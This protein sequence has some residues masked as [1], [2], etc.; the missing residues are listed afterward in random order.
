MY[1]TTVNRV[2]TTVI[3]NV[4]N[5]RITNVTVTRVSYNG[6]GG[7]QYR[8][9]PAEVMAIREQHTPPM[10]A[11]VQ[12]RQQAQTNRAMFYNSNHGRPA[13]VTESRP[14]AADRNVRPPAQI[15][16]ARGERPPV[17]KAIQQ[18]Q[19]A[20]APATR[21]EVRPNEQHARPEAHTAP[22]RTQP[23][24]PESRPAPQQQHAQPQ[25]PETQRATPQ[26]PEAQHA[27]PRRSAPQQEHG[28]TAPEKKPAPQHAAPR[29]QTHTTAQHKPEP[30]KKKP[31][32][33]KPE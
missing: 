20:A 28:R 9:R 6:P 18:Q 16:Y 12:I 11:Q 13:T 23:G 10:T 5:Y 8:P 4:Y 22:E 19:R 7:A 24:R 2:N 25:R 21:P 17:P 3:R 14:L 29:E 1:N 15:N 33:K 26:R 27:A 31:E 32:E 30:Q